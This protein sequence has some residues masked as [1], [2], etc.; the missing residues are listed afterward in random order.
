M[1]KEDVDP[2]LPG[3]FGEGLQY[4]FVGGSARFLAKD[5]PT[6]IVSGGAGFC[7]RVGK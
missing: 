2:G 5:L 3:S 7:V 6:S 1:L 4:M